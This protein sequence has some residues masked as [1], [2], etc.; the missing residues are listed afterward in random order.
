MPLEAY[1][2]LELL[3]DGVGLRTYRGR[4]AA[5]RAVTLK[6][7]DALD[8]GARLRLLHESRVLGL[9]VE[10]EGGRVLLVAPFHA[11]E[12]LRERLRRGP[13]TLPEWLRYARSLAAG[14]AEVHSQ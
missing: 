7:T 10:E 6:V 11:G 13:L 9:D 8:A 4:D 14:L 3:K 12:T 5:G 1:A 2:P